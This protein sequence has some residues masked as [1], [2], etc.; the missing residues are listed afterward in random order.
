MHTCRIRTTTDREFQTWG[1]INLYPSIVH[2]SRDNSLLNHLALIISPRFIISITNMNEV[3]MNPRCKI[4]H[5]C[6]P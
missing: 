3:D 5:E 1:L 2:L 6:Y 4:R